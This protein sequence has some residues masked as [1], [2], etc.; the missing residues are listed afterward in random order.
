[1]SKL[2]AERER[3]LVVAYESHRAAGD[4]AFAAHNWSEALERYTA[5][6]AVRANG[7]AAARLRYCRHV[8]DG[9]NQLNLRQFS[10][11]A[12]SF[13]AAAETGQD[14]DR[15]AVA[16]LRKV[17]PAVYA[18]KLD[19]FLVNST[20]ASKQPWVRET[21]PWMGQLAGLLGQPVLGTLITKLEA[22]P[23]ELMPSTWARIAL[24]DGRV[25]QTRRERGVYRI[26][27]ATVYVRTNHYDE[28]K[29]TIEVKG[30][31]DREST[32]GSV[33]VSL[34]ELVR[35]GSFA[36]NEGGSG[37]LENTQD[38]LLNLRISVTPTQT[39]N[40]SFFEN[41]EPEA[42]D[43]NKAPNPMLPSRTAV[44]CRVVAARVDIDARDYRQE[45]L[46]GPPDPVL[47]LKSGN[48]VVFLTPA[49][50]DAFHADWHFEKSYLYL[51]AGLPF[52]IA[53]ID[54]DVNSH[55]TIASWQYTAGSGC[56]PI[57]ARTA[58]GSSF[59]I[60][61]EPLPEAQPK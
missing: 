52:S 8:V 39:Q 58:N 33:D 9:A 29:L 11:A 57:Q 46:D 40:P 42:D 24:P 60:Q 14:A 6:E 31:G 1:V 34:G 26:P 50:Q 61:L 23:K 35:T 16:E 5:A 43:N 7:P 32:A 44:A 49:K 41:L 12:A 22:M 25:L 17:E 37:R 19:R 54:E 47:Q 27:N 45:M 48:R 55:D 2:R 20:D 18:I 30:S 38:A 51:T 13:R 53:L 56:G 3:A 10:A 28:R 21:S 15:L 36:H 4:Q 59:A